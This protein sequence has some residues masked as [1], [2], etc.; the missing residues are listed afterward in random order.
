MTAW[1]SESVCHPQEPPRARQHEGPDTM[2]EA[3]SFCGTL[4]RSVSAGRA[5]PL[6]CTLRRRLNCCGVGKSGRPMSCHSWYGLLMLL[7]M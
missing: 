3:E 7:S 4:L 2:T 5:S 6:T 1:P